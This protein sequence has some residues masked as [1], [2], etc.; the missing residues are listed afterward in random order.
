LNLRDSHYTCAALNSSIELAEKGKKPWASDLTKAIT[1]LPFH[2][3][4]LALTHQTTHKNVENYA[5]L[6]CKLITEQLQ[7]ETEPPDKPHLL[8][9]Q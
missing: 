7:E 9:G 4:K 6:M 8:H 1:R 2:C 3:P 5:K